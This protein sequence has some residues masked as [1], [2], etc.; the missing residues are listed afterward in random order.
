MLPYHCRQIRK[1]VTLYIDSHYAGFQR[2]ETIEEYLDEYR[3]LAEE[4]ARLTP[5]DSVVLY[6]VFEYDIP[7]QTI[8]SADFVM[9]EIPYDMYTELV[10]KLI[11]RTRF[12]FIRGRKEYYE[13]F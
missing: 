5:W 3:L 1:D 13:D 2:I 4:K 7:G 8:I 12:F 11:D 6:A 9:L 10:E